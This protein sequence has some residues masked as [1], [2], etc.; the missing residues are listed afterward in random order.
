MLFSLV[1]R[2]MVFPR[3]AMLTT[4]QLDKVSIFVLT[5]KKIHASNTGERWKTV[6]DAFVLLE[7]LST[8][9]QTMF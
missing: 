9:E 6:S 1:V 4:L 8:Q 2:L 7:S 3:N 5:T